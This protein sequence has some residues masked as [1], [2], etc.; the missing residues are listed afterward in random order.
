MDVELREKLNAIHGTALNKGH[1]FII[2]MLVVLF[3]ATIMADERAAKIEK[4]LGFV[5][6]SLGHG[7]RTHERLTE[8]YVRFY[9]LEKQLDACVKTAGR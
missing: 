5:E 3:V 4:K 8:I 6:Q 7:G 9:D 1:G 2:V